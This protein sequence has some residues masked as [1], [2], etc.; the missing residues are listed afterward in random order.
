MG[1]SDVD[2]VYAYRPVEVG[3]CILKIGKQRHSGFGWKHIARDV[4]MCVCVWWQGERG[5]KEP[6][7]ILDYQVY[8]FL[9]KLKPYENKERGEGHE[10]KE[11]VGH[12]RI[13]AFQ[14][15]SCLSF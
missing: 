9:K 5:K 14:A 13:R 10:R 2:S 4:C 12:T 3:L 15:Q 1:K 8:F 7:S 11:N 6:M